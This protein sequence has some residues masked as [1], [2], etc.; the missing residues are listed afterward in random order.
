[1]F[2]KLNMKYYVLFFLNFT[3]MFIKTNSINCF[4]LC[5]II[6][7]RIII[8]YDKYYHNALQ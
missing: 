7:I 3:D 2:Y 6:I 8:I 1:M 5:Y 4:D